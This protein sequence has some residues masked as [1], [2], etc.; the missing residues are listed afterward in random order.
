MLLI[1]GLLGFVVV[2]LAYAVKCDRDWQ[3]HQ[4][5]VARLRSTSQT[6]VIGTPK[7][8]A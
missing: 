7:R 1:I 3:R 4:R 8:A 5:I 2:T 6:G